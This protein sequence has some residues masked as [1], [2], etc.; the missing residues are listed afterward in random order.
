M[1]CDELECEVHIGVHEVPN[2]KVVI[3]VSLLKQTS[4]SFSQAVF[5]DFRHSARSLWQ[6]QIEASVHVEEIA[7]AVLLGKPSDE[8]ETHIPRQVSCGLSNAF[9]VVEMENGG[10]VDNN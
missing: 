10:L 6:A 3:Q 7:S 5:P 8:D 2:H 9:A 4:S 1:R